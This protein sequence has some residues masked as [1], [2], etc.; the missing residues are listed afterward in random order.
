MLAGPED[1]QAPGR[2]PLSGML[3]PDT[4]GRHPPSRAAADS[5]SNGLL[6]VPWVPVQLSPHVSAGSVR[7]CGCGQGFATLTGPRSPPPPHKVTGAL[8]P[9][10]KRGGL[11]G[12]RQREVVQATAKPPSR[13]EESHAPH[14]VSG[15]P[16][17]VLLS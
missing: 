9:S 6:P 11:L 3:L 10:G 4:G 8:H 7:M 16:P 5:P 15:S 14:G 17:V 13:P 12:V 2:D 1:G